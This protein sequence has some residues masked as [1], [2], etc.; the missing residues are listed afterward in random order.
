MDF[1]AAY[2][3]PE[4]R[5]ATDILKDWMNKNNRSPFTFGKLCDDLMDIYGSHIIEKI[6][7]ALLRLKVAGELQVTYKLL[8]TATK[9]Y[10][11]YY[12]MDFDHDLYMIVPFYDTVN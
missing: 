5:E 9:E 6:N 10:S 3:N 1:S 8:N 2:D 11:D 7:R 4:L 12:S